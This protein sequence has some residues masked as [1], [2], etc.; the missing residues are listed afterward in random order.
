MLGFVDVPYFQLQKDLLIIKYIKPVNYDSRRIIRLKQTTC[1]EYYGQLVDL[2]L[3]F[4][5]I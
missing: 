5:A 2:S 3:F 4:S 1:D